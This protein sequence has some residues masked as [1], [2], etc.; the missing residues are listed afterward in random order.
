MI[1]SQFL[2]AC[3]FAIPV[4]L[5]TAGCSRVS[6]ESSTRSRTTETAK[7]V[8]I[9]YVRF[10]D[11]HHG[12][13]SLYF[14][15]MLAFNGG[16]TKVTD[17]KSLPAERRQFALKTA[18][19]ADAIATNS[20]G[21]DKEKHYTVVAFDDRTGK[22]SLR[23]VNDDEK[24]PDVGKAKV[25]IL[26]ASPDMEGIKLYAHGRKDEIATQSRFTTGSNWQE[27]DPVKGDLELRTT[28]KKDGVVQIP[29]VTL[30]AGKLYT[31]IV[32]GGSDTKERLNVSTIIDE[33]RS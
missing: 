30:Q 23:V 32:R 11:A 3:V 4:L 1:R 28:D 15:D 31:F 8:D 6:D 17:Y 14:G 2:K 19:T 33:P 16:G 29:D 7:T 26:H 10:V 22:A 21:L 18:A 12:S 25:R 20:E 5:T 24:A 13:E 9:S 27:I